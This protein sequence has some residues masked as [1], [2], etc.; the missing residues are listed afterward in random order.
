[1]SCGEYF[2]QSNNYPNHKFLDF[3]RPIKAPTELLTI[4]EEN[5]RKKMFRT[6]SIYVECNLC[7]EGVDFFVI[8]H[9]M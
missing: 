8:E 5:S 9:G 6:M 1:M 4:L 3:L 7:S 2:T